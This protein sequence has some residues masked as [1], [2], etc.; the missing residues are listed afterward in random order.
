MQNIVKNQVHKN[1]YGKLR[2]P[3]NL[4]NSNEQVIVKKEW[5]QS[6]DVTFPAVTVCNTNPVKQS[7][8]YLSPRL[9]ALVNRWTG[10]N[11]KR[12]RKRREVTQDD[13]SDASTP[14]SRDNDVHRPAVRVKRCKCSLRF[15]ITSVIAC[16]TCPVWPDIHVK[17]FK[18]VNNISLTWILF[19][20][21][22]YYRLN[23]YE[24][25]SG[26]FDS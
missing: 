18:H 26:L 23:L 11:R 22:S 8:L 1:L 3:I 16:E 19:L 10:E 14:V 7:L 13:A 5:V 17:T 20:F 9:S 2:I 6:T 4:K 15:L 12:R 21:A 25:L 24:Q